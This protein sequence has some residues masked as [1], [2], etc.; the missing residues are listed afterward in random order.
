MK[1]QQ[2]ITTLN[3]PIPTLSWLYSDLSLI[4]LH[5]MIGVYDFIGLIAMKLIIPNTSQWFY[6]TL[7]EI[8]YVMY[9]FFDWLSTGGI[10]LMPSF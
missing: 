7:C 3:I 1:S 9:V 5:N 10:F 2:I 4:I 8:S 6:H